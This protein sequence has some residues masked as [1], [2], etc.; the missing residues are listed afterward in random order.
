MGGSEHH[1]HRGQLWLGED[2]GGHG[3]RQVVKSALGG[4]SRNG[5]DY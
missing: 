3:D 2:V 4:Y 5:I 1:R